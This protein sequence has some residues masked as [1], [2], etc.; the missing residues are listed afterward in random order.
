MTGVQTCAL[1]I[2]L[3]PSLVAAALLVQPISWLSALPY[4]L[5]FYNPIVG[6]GSTAERLIL[7]GWG[8]GLD[9]VA[10]YLNA[11]PDAE[12]ATIGVFYPLTVNFQ[13]LLRGTAINLGGSTRPTYV[14]D[15][16]NARQRAQTP[17][18]VRDRMPDF[19]V[20]INGIDYARVYR[21]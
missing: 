14:V 3:G 4:P 17:S 18:Y 6:G 16:V 13:A 15:Y 11:Q 1:P 19:V 2:S 10:A 9:Q 8:E 7:V 12:V 5:S 20:R 21:T